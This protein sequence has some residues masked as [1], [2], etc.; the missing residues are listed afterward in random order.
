MQ[1]FLAQG[2]HLTEKRTGVLIFASVAERYAE[3]IADS[4]ID[5]KVN[6]D[7]WTGAIAAMVLPSRTGVR[8]T[9]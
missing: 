7:A 4:G 9:A 8:A 1:Q 5:A 3:I 6:P 2:I